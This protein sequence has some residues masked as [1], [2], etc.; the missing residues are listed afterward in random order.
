[1]EKIPIFVMYHNN[2]AWTK[3]CLAYLKK[4]T[5]NYDLYL[6]D[7]GSHERCAKQIDDIGFVDFELL[8]FDNP[9]SVTFAYNSAIKKFLKDREQFVILHND[10]FVT[11]GWLDALYNS[12]KKIKDEDPT[13][14][15]SCVFPR[16]CYSNEGSA[17]RYDQEVFGL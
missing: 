17:T 5:K 16:S 10:V 12:Y 1:M 2:F 7:N 8:R 4:N 11:E 14:G 9:V 13:F 3:L 6:I 15:I